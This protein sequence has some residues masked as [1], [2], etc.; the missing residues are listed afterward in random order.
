MVPMHV[1]KLLPQLALTSQ[2]HRLYGLRLTLPAQS[3]FIVDRQTL[4]TL[5]M[6][7]LTF[8]FSTDNSLKDVNDIGT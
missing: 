8:P 3:D 1:G 4:K 7:Y 2:I 5:S 6:R